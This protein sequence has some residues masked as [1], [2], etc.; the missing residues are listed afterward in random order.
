MKKLLEYLICISFGVAVTLTTVILTDKPETQ[1]VNKF[2]KVKT[3]NG[4]T[5]VDVKSTVEPEERK[6]FRLFGRGK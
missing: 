2:R 5:N 3:K 6:R 4:T 1:I